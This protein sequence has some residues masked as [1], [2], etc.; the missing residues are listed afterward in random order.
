MRNFLIS[1]TL[2]SHRIVY[3]KY[4]DIYLPMRKSLQS[5][6]SFVHPKAKLTPLTGATLTLFYQMATND[7]ARLH[8]QNY[9]DS[10]TY[11]QR[12]SAALDI[13]R[14]QPRQLQLYF[15]LIGFGNIQADNDDDND[16]NRD[17]RGE[18][19]RLVG[20]LGVLEYYGRIERNDMASLL[21]L[22]TYDDRTIFTRNGVV[23][24]FHYLN[25]KILYVVL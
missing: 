18:S 8:V 3:G 17:R 1:E 19:I 7:G 10:Y 25:D 14:A 13:F 5:I 20:M 24:R 21:E 2:Y 6:V 22:T 4:A 9:E 12:Y 16:D 11:A 23:E 15:L